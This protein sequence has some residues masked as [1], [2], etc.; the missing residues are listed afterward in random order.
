MTIAI[1]SLPYTPKCVSGVRTF[2]LAKSL[3]AF[4]ERRAV[5]LAHGLFLPVTT[6]RP[7]SQHG[8]LF[9]CIAG[10]NYLFE[11]G[12]EVEILRGPAVPT[13]LVNVVHLLCDFGLVECVDGQVIRSW[14]RD[15]SEHVEQREVRGQRAA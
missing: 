13:E 15:V 14:C 2:L 10:V 5:H 7:H 1:E 8:Q 11:L 9:G 6:V 4:S 12:F 3:Y